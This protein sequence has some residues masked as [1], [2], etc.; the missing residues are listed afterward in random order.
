MIAPSHNSLCEEA[1]PYYY[2]FLFNESE[3]SVPESIINHIN[4]C[5]HCQ[6]QLNQLKSVL[7]QAESQIEPEKMEG[8]SAIIEMLKLHF[9]YIAKSVTCRTVKPFLPTLLEPH[10]EIEMPT[11]ITVH[12]V[13]CHQ[14]SE[15]LET[16]RKLNLS[17]KQLR[18]LS[19]LFADEPDMKKVNCE[20]VHDNITVIVSMAF[21]ETS[22]EVLKH[23]SIC[24]HCCNLLYQHRE[25]IRE[26]HLHKKTDQKYFP[27]QNV[28]TTDIFDYVVPYGLAPST[29]DYAK[30]RESLV[31]HL[32]TCPKC[33]AKMQQLHNTMYTIIERPE[34]G[35][36]TR[37][38]IDQSAKTKAVSESDDTYAGFPIRVEVTGRE[39][40]VNTEQSDPV[41]DFTTALKQKVSVKKLKPLLKTA[42]AAAAVIFIA[43]A[44]LLNIPSAKAITL[45][46]I[47]KVFKKVKNVHITSFTAGR[48]EPTQERW[49]SRTTNTYLLKT[50]KELVL[51]DTGNSIRKS[52]QVA[53]GVIDTIPLS[54]DMVDEIKNK[55]AGFL[56]LVPFAGLSV[57]PK[58]AS[59]S[60]VAGESL[61]A[62]VDIETYDLTWA[63]KT[64]DDSDVTC[65]WRVF[66]D[67]KTALP[68]KTELYDK[69]PTDNEYTLR[70]VKVI[71]Y[72][73][74]SE[75]QEVIK[76]ASF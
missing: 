34:S 35:V 33:L 2:H 60:P 28:S 65:K 56:G 51:W 11:P 37:F 5:Q 47:Y 40:K 10:L 58:D 29:D 22:E 62:A 3:E 44:L 18:R 32:R 24:P 76:E 12:L 50:K 75:M 39:N 30:L 16:I 26:E 13:N 74:D 6:Q 68:Q 67:L 8:S 31:S 61:E 38:Y 23:V 54:V 25:A 57:V 59:W 42:A 27:C 48:S 72:P 49:V 1:E 45:E 69:L 14:C 7:S 15:D 55:I 63:E 73:S 66:V 46:R 70:S 36:V 71:E 17:R 52:K 4:Q 9:A 64:R 41:I 43:V 53:T 21:D 20:Q 19:Q